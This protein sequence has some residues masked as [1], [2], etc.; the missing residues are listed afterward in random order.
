MTHGRSVA[1]WQGL[2]KAD[3]AV[4]KRRIAGIDHGAGA[5]K[6]MS[7]D[8]CRDGEHMGASLVLRRLPC[9]GRWRVPPLSS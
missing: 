1:L 5:L 4:G 7:G 9:G 6:R 2:R 3:G 8:R